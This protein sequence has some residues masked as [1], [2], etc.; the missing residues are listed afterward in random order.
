MQQ[1]PASG[2]AATIAA[3]G[4]PL[5]L[6]GLNLAALHAVMAVRL[7]AL[8]DRAQREPLAELT[9]RF[10]S[11]EAASAVLELVREITSTWPEPFV[12]NRPCCLALS[13]DEATLAAMVRQ[14]ATGNRAD[15]SASLE[16]FVR[17]ERH[18][19][20]YTGTVRAVALLQAVATKG[21]PIE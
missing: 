16:G 2:F 5:D 14:A 10:R 12:T 13:P 21:A 1:A 8:F 3:L 18:E 9:Q 6:R 17:K 11:F 7:C 20:L 19:R 15:F 4:R